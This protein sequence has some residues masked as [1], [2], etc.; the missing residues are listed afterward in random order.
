MHVT[1]CKKIWKKE[2]TSK[3]R[4]QDKN[5]NQKA[6]LHIVPCT[7]NK[8]SLVSLHSSSWSHP[9]APLN[10][11]IVECGKIWKA[12]GGVPRFFVLVH[13]SISHIWHAEQTWDLILRWG[14]ENVLFGYRAYCPRG[15]LMNHQKTPSLN[16]INYCNYGSW[17]SVRKIKSHSLSLMRW[18]NDENSK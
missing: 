4:N 5:L 15:R 10:H 14:C 9:H 17:L 18:W 2:Q 13:H 16:Q 1:R 11:V 8:H 7:T 6:P 3:I 12:G